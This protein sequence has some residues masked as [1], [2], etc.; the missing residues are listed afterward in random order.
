MR[1]MVVPIISS[2]PRGPRAVLHDAGIVPLLAGEAVSG[3]DAYGD[4][5]DGWLATVTSLVLA[6]RLIFS[7]ALVPQIG[8]EVVEVPKRLIRSI[9]QR[10]V[11]LP[12]DSPALRASS[13]GSY[14]ETV[15]IA[16]SRPSIRSHVHCV[17]GR[18]QTASRVRSLSS[19]SRVF[20]L[21]AACWHR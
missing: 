4:R 19:R 12:G 15:N 17:S 10:N 21:S 8:V 6:L 3:G 20:C 14:K 13:S 18:H 5:G 1:R 7:S 11:D 9:A 16:V 2:I